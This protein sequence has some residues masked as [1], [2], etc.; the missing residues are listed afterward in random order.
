MHQHVLRIEERTKIKAPI[1]FFFYI[2]KPYDT[3]CSGFYP[4]HIFSEFSE[5]TT[6]NQKIVNKF[7][8]FSEFS[9]STTK[10]VNKFSEFSE[11]TV[12]QKRKN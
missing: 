3:I 9:E 8:E 12:P 1:R 7:S 5:R 4:M 2:K 11:R 10:L 6:K